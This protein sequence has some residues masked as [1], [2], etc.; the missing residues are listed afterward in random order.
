[1][2]GPFDVTYDPK[3]SD[4][5]ALQWFAF[6]KRY[7]RF[8]LAVRFPKC[9]AWLDAYEPSQDSQ[10]GWSR[11]A[12]WELQRYGE[13]TSET[14]DLIWVWE[15]RI[16][17]CPAL[18]EGRL[19]RVVHPDCVLT[20]SFGA[21]K[22]AKVSVARGDDQSDQPEAKRGVYPYMN[23]GN[24]RLHAYQLRPV[25]LPGTLAGFSDHQ[26]LVGLQEGLDICTTAVISVV[27]QGAIANIYAGPE[28]N[29]QENMG[30]GFRIW[31]GPTEPKMMASA[32]LSPA[33]VPA[34]EL[35][36]ALMKARAGSNQVIGGE[37]PKGMPGNAMA[38][39]YTQALQYVNEL[40]QGMTKVFSDSRTGRIYLYK[41]FATDERVAQIAGEGNTWSM[42]KWTGP[43]NLSDVERVGV[44]EIPAALRTEAGRQQAVEFLVA[45][46]LITNKQEVLTLWATGQDKPMWK[47]DQMNLLRIRQ[48]VELL[49]KGIGLP[50]VKMNPDGS[51]IVGQGGLPVFVDPPPVPGQLPP[52]FIRPTLFDS[53]WY[54]IPEYMTVIAS[55]TARAN[56]QV[57]KATTE[58]ITIK[59]AMWSM[60]PPQ[61]QAMLGCPPDRIRLPMPPPGAVGSDGK[62]AQPPAAPQAPHAGP[63]GA[64]I[65]QPKPPADPTSG[66][67]APVTQTSQP[68]TAGPGVAA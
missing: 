18:P 15:A 8:D 10:D 58:A 53:P 29:Y 11:E 30:G 66:S 28:S 20:D 51:P 65:Q 48:E 4:D 16:L 31:E 17:P 52:P 56:P 44:E 5:E 46:G 63:P 19:V 12:D 32:E 61:R 9:K 6:R 33:V 2:G 3:T 24:A 43:G 1:V 39:L 68:G 21:G 50:P 54:E 22:Q 35:I 62:P 26:D 14:T 57:F 37:T 55:P 41:E 40:A 38:L 42:T 49:R 13:T 27:N 25:A 64:Q 45:N 47:G 60:M 67:K 59:E 36:R 7:N 23:Q 34:L